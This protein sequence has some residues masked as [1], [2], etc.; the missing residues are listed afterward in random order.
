MSGEYADPGRRRQRS[1]SLG[2]SGPDRWLSRSQ[3][4]VPYDSAVG[5]SASET[6]RSSG[7]GSTYVTVPALGETITEGMVTRWLKQVGDTVAL[8]EPLLEL[9]TDKVDTEIPSPATG[10]VLEIRVAEDETAEVGAV[11]A[12]IGDARPFHLLPDAPAGDA[13]LVDRD[14]AEPAGAKRFTFVE[15][16]VQM[17]EDGVNDLLGAARDNLTAPTGWNSRSHGTRTVAMSRIVASLSE[18][19]FENAEFALLLND[20]TAAVGPNAPEPLPA[21][22]A[23]A[24][25]QEG[26][27]FVVHGHDHAKLYLAV[28]VLERATG[29]EV[30][31]LHEQANSGRTI[32]EKFE[33]HAQTAAYAVVLLTADD[34]GGLAGAG[35][36]PRGR[37]NVIFE[38][39]FFYGK[40]G[41]DRVAV[42][43][44]QGVEEPSDIKGLVYVSLD[45]AGAWKQQLGRELE[46][47][48]IP[49]NYSRMP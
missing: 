1:A 43:L 12:V 10:I 31:V 11:L 7:D 23:P 8:D 9:S 26:P 44:E 40:L 27:I 30:I 24:V 5:N 45:S 32:L 48:G 42:L 25:S 39:G 21:G 19:E 29:R 22:A 38:L 14:V 35:V 41:R 28:R 13:G 46:A 15:R 47:A 33:Q 34:Q 6:G 4:W 17:D 2:S 36:Q 18:T 49:V 20:R 3:N 37:Q 16:L